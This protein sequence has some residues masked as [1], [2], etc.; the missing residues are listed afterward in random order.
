MDF[1]LKLSG[2]ISKIKIIISQKYLGMSLI[3]LR[4]YT[5]FHTYDFSDSLLV[6]VKPKVKE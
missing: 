3:Y 5:R 6:P 4:V 2:V 1:V